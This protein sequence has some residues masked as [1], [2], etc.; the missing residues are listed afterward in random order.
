MTESAEQDLIEIW[1]F[2]AA[3]NR[4]AASKLVREIQARFETVQDH[5]EIGPRRDQRASGQRAGQIPVRHVESLASTAA[6]P[7]GRPPSSTRRS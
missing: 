6:T 4:T 2:I 5:P 3:D 1:S 7:A